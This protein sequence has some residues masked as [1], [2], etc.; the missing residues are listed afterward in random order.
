MQKLKTNFF[1][2]PFFP[3]K[4]MVT[5]FSTK[6]CFWKVFALTAAL[7]GA[8]FR[9]NE[10][11][12]LGGGNFDDDD[13]D[14]DNNNGNGLQVPAGC[15]MGRRRSRAVLYQLSGHYKPEKVKT[16]LKLSNV[17]ILKTFKFNFGDFS[18]VCRTFCTHKRRRFLNTKHQRWKNHVSYYTIMEYL[19]DFGIGLF[20]LLRFM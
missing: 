20:L 10:S 13:D 6:I 9:N 5:L 18:P 7:L 15:N 3:K 2:Q 1:S 19:K 12:I 14:D 8:R 11:S 4:L 16:K 17:S